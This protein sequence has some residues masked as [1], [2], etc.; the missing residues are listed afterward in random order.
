MSSCAF[1][2]SRDKKITREHVFPKAIGLSMD[3]SHADKW[4]E[5]SPKRFVGGEI[6][7]KDVCEDCNS[8]PL[9]ELDA[10]AK[11]IYDSYLYQKVNQD[12]QITFSYYF[13]QLSRWLLKI[14]FN[15]ARVNN[16]DTTILSE[17]IPY[18]LN[19]EEVENEFL[20]YVHLIR[21]KEFSTEEIRAFDLD[22]S[23]KKEYPE[24]WR[25]SQFRL[26][27]FH[28]I[29]F[30][31]RFVFIN[32]FCFS[33]LA[34]PKNI[35]NESLDKIKIKFEEEYEHSICL[36]ESDG[37]VTIKTGQIDAFDAFFPHMNMN[38]EFYSDEYLG[39][40]HNL[41]HKYDTG[42]IVIVIERKEVEAGDISRISSMFSNIFISK[43]TILR[44]K[45][46]IDLI[47]DGYDDD[48]RGLFLIPEARKF[49]QDLHSEFP[50]WFYILNPELPFFKILPYML[51]EIEHVEDVVK[52]S[53]DNLSLFIQEG[54][55][56][57]NEFCYNNCLS[58]ETI[59]EISMEIDKS[60][61]GG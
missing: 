9:S 47:F 16:A 3:D 14:C 33:V 58:E 5:R 22:V 60:I 37:K 48:E 32:S 2:G 55:D 41:V 31:Q 54:F 27:G 49:V 21:P 30:V 34:F 8:G 11:E 6:V 23:E 51:Y 50:Y 36:N 35:S 57:L 1:C 4:V 10:Y 29:S 7:I 53:D 59:Y 26:Q 28:E 38:P 46:S 19:G 42:L 13:D 12:D 18:I 61:N 24:G 17:F 20:I 52:I 43:K 25:L 56:K 15:S 39:D 40:F 45:Q 44:C